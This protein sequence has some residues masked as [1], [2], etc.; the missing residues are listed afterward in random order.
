M[1][2]QVDKGYGPANVDIDAQYLAFKNGKNSITWDGIWQINDLEA[3]GIELR[4]RA[5]PGH[6]RRSP[7]PGRTPTTSS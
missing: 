6:R 5:D 3:A 1:R 2:E 4:H 7:P